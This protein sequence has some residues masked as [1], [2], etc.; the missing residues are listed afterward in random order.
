MGYGGARRLRTITTSGIFES[1]C[2]SDR[3]FNRHTGFSGQRQTQSTLGSWTSTNCHML[4]IH[5][6]SKKQTSDVPESPS[7]LSAWRRIWEKIQL[8]L[9]RF[10]RDHNTLLVPGKQQILPT[11]LGHENTSNVLPSPVKGSMM[12]SRRQQEQPSWHLRKGREADAVWYYRERSWS[13]RMK[14]W[15]HGIDRDAFSGSGNNCNHTLSN[16]WTEYAFTS[17]RP[18]STDTF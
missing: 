11:I 10:G 9:K 5:S 6:G 8:P 2:Y 17:Y 7:S 15:R 18:A 1:T 13:L 12:F 14:Y 4:T 3:I 16:A